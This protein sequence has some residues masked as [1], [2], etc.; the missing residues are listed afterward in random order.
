[1]KYTVKRVENFE[2][3]IRDGLL[4]IKGHYY[5]LHPLKYFDNKE[6][7]EFWIEDGELCDPLYDKEFMGE[8][9]FEIVELRNIKALRMNKKMSQS[10]L[11]NASGV[12]V[13]MI[14]KYEGG[15]KDINKAQAITVYKLA[16]ALECDV[17]D[18]LEFE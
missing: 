16:Q 15:H 2:G 1:M 12:P 6:D 8:C 11:A 9:T 4:D 17:A 10:Q 5:G 14:Q 18:L 3:T 7:A 13:V